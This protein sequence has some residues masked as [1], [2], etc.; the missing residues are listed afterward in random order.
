MC[1]RVVTDGK[2][3]KDVIGPNKI[4]GGEANPKKQ[5]VLES[6]LTI[7]AKP[8]VLFNNCHKN[9]RIV[10]SEMEASRSL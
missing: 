6:Q 4:E 9:L 2:L 10:S 1:G 7:I 8:F 3:E 5:R